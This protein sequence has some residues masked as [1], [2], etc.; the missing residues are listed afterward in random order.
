M[1]IPLLKTAL[2]AVASTIKPTAAKLALAGVHDI[3]R[4]V[5][6][7]AAKDRTLDVSDFS[8]HAKRNTRALLG[9]PPGAVYAI[10]I[11]LQAAPPEVA[12]ELPRLETALIRVRD[13]AAYLSDAAQTVLAVLDAASPTKPR[14]AM[15]TA[16]PPDPD[17][18]PTPHHYPKTAPPDPPDAPP[19]TT[20]SVHGRLKS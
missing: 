14:G 6:A 15:P 3:A 18:E 11:A 20:K 19:R 8:V 1:F 16:A 13:D 7:N 2:G 10:K 17:P 12:R 4:R 9:L 5:A